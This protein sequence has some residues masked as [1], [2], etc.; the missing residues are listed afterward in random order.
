[1]K[2]DQPL[3]DIRSLIESVPSI[4]VSSINN[5]DSIIKEHD[6]K[7]YLGANVNN[8]KLLAGWQGIITKIKKPLISIFAG[9]HGVAES[10]FDKDI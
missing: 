3:D 9:T 2:N 10:V 6:L 4:D 8:I 1:M 7:H 5:I